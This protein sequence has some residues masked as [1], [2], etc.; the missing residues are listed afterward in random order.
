[1][2]SIPYAGNRKLRTAC[3]LLSL[4]LGQGGLPVFG[5]HEIDS[6]ALRRRAVASI[7]YAANRK[8]RT[9]CGLLSLHLGQGG[10][11]V[12]C[13]HEIDTL[14]KEIVDPPVVVEGHLLQA[15]GG[16]AR[17]IYRQLLHLGHSRLGRGRGAS[18]NSAVSPRIASSSDT[19]FFAISL[20]L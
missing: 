11:P 18:S 15:P 7:P 8:L 5:Q 10:L 6:H 9:A 19:R 4:H 12:F 14:L 1:M 16:C 17:H 3:G 2:A 13:Q 20:P